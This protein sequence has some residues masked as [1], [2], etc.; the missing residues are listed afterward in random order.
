MI[1]FYLF[2]TKPTFTQEALWFDIFHL[3]VQSS[4]LFFFFSSFH[5]TL[6]H[7]YGNWGP[8]VHRKVFNIYSRIH[9]TFFF[10]FWVSYYFIIS[11]II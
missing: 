2:H 3:K 9:L 8:Q 7:C 5:I 10:F 4:L 1:L 6:R 11:L